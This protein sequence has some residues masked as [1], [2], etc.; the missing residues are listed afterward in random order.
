M[1]VKVN[2][3][4]HSVQTQNPD[5]ASSISAATQ[6]EVDAGTATGVY[7]EPA[8]LENSAQLAAKQATLVSGTNIKTINSNSL[9][10]A[11]DLVIS[12]GGGTEA[13]FAEA[14][15]G[16][17]STQMMSPRRVHQVYPKVYNVEAYGAV[18]D[19]STDDTAAIQSA[20]NAC[21]AAGGGT[22][23]FPNGIY[24]IAGALVTSLGGVNPNCQIYIP[25]APVDNSV[26]VQITI[27][28]ESNFG[29]GFYGTKNTSGGVILR[30]TIAGSGSYP[31]VFGSMGMTGSYLNYNL[32]IIEFRNISVRTYTNSGA[33]AASVTPFYM[34]YSGTV[35]FYNCVADLDS[36]I[37]TSVSPVSSEVAGFVVSG[38]WDNGPNVIDQCCAMGYKYAYVI[39]EHTTLNNIYA[40]G[41]YYGLV[42]QASAYGAVGHTLIHAC[43]TGILISN[44]GIMGMDIQTARVYLDITVDYEIDTFSLWYDTVKFLVDSSNMG[45]GRIRY[46]GS[47]GPGANLRSTTT[48]GGNLII[49]GV[50][51]WPL[52]FSQSG[53]TVPS[54]LG[55]T[56][57][58][59]QASTGLS[60]STSD[61]DAIFS[62]ATN[63]ANTSIAPVGKFVALNTNISASDKRMMLLGCYTNGANN[64]SILYLYNMIAGSLREIFHADKGLN[65]SIP[66]TMPN[67]ADDASADTASQG[68]TA[69]KGTVYYNTT[70]D[71]LKIKENATWKTI[72]TS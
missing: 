10:G 18:H 19:N 61:G 50:W 57:A 36:P 7:V 28:G 48:G 2:A 40:I 15:A 26:V 22:V 59:I 38:W 67:Y 39:G 64:T 4:S 16:T 1:K 30:S 12:G 63:Q 27:L 33:V 37:N 3:I 11:G 31:A 68:G 41:N 45:Y 58:V 35:S 14:L 52:K 70:S 34:R 20:I 46:I 51:D 13:T 17:G 8:T 44:A 54:I 43:N 23:Y 32:T 71:K 55:S 24:K 72:T 66:I 25:Q 5:S 60:G 29:L 42:F 53:G 9:L 21:F 62:A 69:P 49:S 56:S 47:P 6:S 65:I